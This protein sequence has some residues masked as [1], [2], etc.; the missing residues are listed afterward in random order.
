V[1]GELL[2]E[3]DGINRALDR[4]LRRNAAQKVGQR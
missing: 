4:I 2:D 3:W 1:L